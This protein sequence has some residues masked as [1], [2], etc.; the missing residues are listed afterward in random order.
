MMHRTGWFLCCGLAAIALAAPAAHATRTATVFVGGNWATA[1]FTENTAPLDSYKDDLPYDQTIIDEAV[2]LLDQAPT[3][4]TV[5]MAL[6]SMDDGGKFED[7]LYRARARNVYVGIAFGGKYA[8]LEQW[9]APGLAW[10]KAC[11]DP[12][13]DDLEEEDQLTGAGCLSGLK[14][15]EMHAKFMTFTKIVRPDGTELQDVVWI[16]SANMTN[17]T[18]ARPFNNSLT[19]YGA[20]QLRQKLVEVWNDM[21]NAGAGS[22]DYYD[23]PS[24]TG[25]FKTPDLETVDDE[26]TWGY[27]SPDSDAS[28][29]MW[30]G[31]LDDI[32][33]PVDGGGPCEVLVMQTFIDPT[34]T[35]QAPIDH[36]V[37]LKNRDCDVKAIV[38]K[39][40]NGNYSI[41]AEAREK[42]YCAGIPVRWA[43]VH[44]KALITKSTT[45]G[46]NNRPQV[47]TGSHNMTYS[48]LRLN[49]E[50]LT[51]TY[52]SESL[53]EA[54]RAHFFDAYSTRAVPFSGTC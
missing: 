13:D 36:L 12:S 31:R 10:L 43:K 41:G 20:P 14:S 6:H 19:V 8:N 35:R 44:D 37:Q 42:L 24:G 34:G 25:Y 29:D 26:D 5:H 2:T 17:Q 3:N 46:V 54:Y 23:P 7:A 15:S 48:A 50:L 4:S 39:R 18:G 38:N 45:E 40:D 52:E 11:D 49:D 27:V 32:K 21:F 53:W 47:M 22:N 30:K 16:S 1:T 33:P 9:A 51:R 28:G